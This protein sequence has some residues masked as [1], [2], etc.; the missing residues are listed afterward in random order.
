MHKNSL[1]HANFSQRRAPRQP[2]NP[3]APAH[4]IYFLEQT[5]EGIY[6]RWLHRRW[7]V[8]SIAATY[9]CTVNDVNAV[10]VEKVDRLEREVAALRRPPQPPAPGRR[11]LAMPKA[12]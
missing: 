3:L 6:Y 4:S 5:K 12:A 10:L 2:L 9:G 11:V 7:K 1:V 8:R